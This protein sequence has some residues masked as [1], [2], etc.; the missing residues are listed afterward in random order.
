ML[1]DFITDRSGAVMCYLVKFSRGG[2]NYTFTTAERPILYGGLTYR[3]DITME[4][5]EFTTEGTLESSSNLEITVPANHPVAQIYK[6]FFPASPMTVQIMIGF[7]ND[8]DLDFKVIW[9]GRVTN[10]LTSEEADS[11]SRT[12]RIVCEQRLKILSRNGLPYRYGITC[13]HMVYKAGCDLS[14]EANEYSATVT[15][16]SG[17]LVTV[18]GISG[19]EGEF[20]SGLMRFGDGDWRDIIAQSGSVLTIIYPMDGM[21]VGSSVRLYRGC[22]RSYSRCSQLGNLNKIFRFNIPSQNVFISGMD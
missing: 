17:Q 12:A 20:V 13:Q 5:P 11:K 18:S 10:V 14:L 22:N 16:I 21:A 6:T 4:I 19:M 1:I 9:P 15:S 7:V 8:P 2:L 3:P